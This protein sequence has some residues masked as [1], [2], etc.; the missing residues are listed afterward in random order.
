MDTKEKICYNYHRKKYK[1][2]TFLDD[3]ITLTRS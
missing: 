1:E 2:L 3:F